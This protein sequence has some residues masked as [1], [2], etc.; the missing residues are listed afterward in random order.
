MTPDEERDVER[1]RE[2][3]I[4][5][6]ASRSHLEASTT[7]ELA[8]ELIVQGLDVLPRAAWPVAFA[9]AVL[10]LAPDTIT[11]GSSLI[12]QGAAGGADQGR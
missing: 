9:M 10:E 1:R 11:F 5:L 8:L 2:A 6:D 7:E 12:D 4:R 3:L